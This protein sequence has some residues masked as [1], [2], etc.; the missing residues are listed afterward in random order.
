MLGSAW[1]TGERLAAYRKYI[2]EKKIEQALPKPISSQIPAS[3]SVARPAEAVTA[4]P[5]DSL[6]TFLPQLG[7]RAASNLARNFRDQGEAVRSTFSALN[8]T[9]EDVIRQ[10]YSEGYWKDMTRVTSSYEA[11][12][13]ETAQPAYPVRFRTLLGFE[14]DYVTRRKLSPQSLDKLESLLHKVATLS[15]RGW[16]LNTVETELLKIA[17][18]GLMK[19]YKGQNARGQ[20]AGFHMSH[21]QMIDDQQ[22]RQGASLQNRQDLLMVDVMNQGLLRA[23]EVEGIQ[24]GHL[25]FIYNDEH[26]LL[27]ASVR[28]A[29]PKTD[30]TSTA[31]QTVF[32]AKRGDRRDTT[33]RLRRLADAITGGA[34]APLFS[35]LGAAGRS[36][37]T[38]VAY[39]YILELIQGWGK[40]VG[41]DGE[42]VGGHSM[43]VG[44]AND[45]FNAGVP[46]DVVMKQG[47][48]KSICWLVYKRGDANCLEFLRKAQPTGQAR[49][50]AATTSVAVGRKEEPEAPSAVAED[51]DASALAEGVDWM[52]DEFERVEEEKGEMAAA[53]PEPLFPPGSRVERKANRGRATYRVEEGAEWVPSEKA[54]FANIRNEETGYLEAVPEPDLESTP[55]GGLGRRSRVASG[56]ARGE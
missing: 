11:Y 7:K 34:R 22:Q 49:S 47:R 1:T 27:G 26:E 46:L 18:R 4:S 2:A 52:L 30:K 45:L 17:R 55:E 39:P 51:V 24:L 10:G 41:L 28:V 33:G 12:C 37:S 38:A 31:G 53:I 16:S 35:V 56:K 19:G 8:E 29:D 25:S 15:E 44:G 3:A 32:L 23:G 43:R 9:I 50:V 54:W 48:W 20:A 5:R 40:R 36:S 21:C 42:R 6:A 14:I 13:E